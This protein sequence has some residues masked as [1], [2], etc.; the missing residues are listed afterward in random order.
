MRTFIWLHR[1]ILFYFYFKSL[2]ILIFC[3]IKQATIISFLLI[4]SKLPHSF[5]ELRWFFPSFAWT[6][7][8]VFGIGTCLA[9]Y[10]HRGGLTSMSLRT[11]STTAATTRVA[12]LWGMYV[13]ST[14]GWSES[15]P[16]SRIFHRM[17]NCPLSAVLLCLIS[18]RTNRG[19]ALPIGMVHF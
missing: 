8:L 13:L 2:A 14:A 3:F 7:Y 9:C 16:L 1:F 12:F 18:S 17:R 19:V 11:S 4:F 5:W 6:E 10:P 15:A